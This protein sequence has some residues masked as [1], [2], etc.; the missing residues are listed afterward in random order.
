MTCRNCNG[1]MCP[2]KVARPE[3]IIEIDMLDF[4]GCQEVVLWCCE[5]CGLT[6]A[7]C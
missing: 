4:A 5:R 1:V 7:E 6:V 2:V 3:E